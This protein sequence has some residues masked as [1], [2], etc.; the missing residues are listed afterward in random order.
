MADLRILV[1]DDSPTM[2]RI[3]VGQLNQAGY[4]DVGDAEDGLDALDELEDGG[5]NFVLT[6][7]NMP[8]MDGLQFIREVRSRE[9]FKDLPILVVTTRNAKQD[10]M[11][12]IK[13]GANNFVVKPFGP[14]TLNEKITKVLQAVGQE[15]RA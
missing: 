3:I 4:Y 10:V 13:E 7:W 9:K 8:N 11:T 12:A 5:Y 6:D 2:R 14:S 1:V 15:A